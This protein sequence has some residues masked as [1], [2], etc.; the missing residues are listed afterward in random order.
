MR[1]LIVT[2]YISTPIHPAFWTKAK[3]TG[4]G[5]IIND[6]AA[7]VGKCEDVDLF[8]YVI[9]SPSISAGDFNIIGHNYL[10]L[11]RFFKF[12][13]LIMAYRFINRYPK[14]SFVEKIKIFGKSL[15]L[16]QLENIIEGYD[17]VHIHGITEA[18]SFAID[19]CKRHNVKFLVTLHG[20]ISFD[21]I[22]DA[23]IGIRCY[24]RD[25]L[26]QAVSEGITVTFVSTGIKK[27]AENYVRKVI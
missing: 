21:E 12:R 25:F 7:Y 23:P 18:T 27:I 16:G 6:I 1:I 15:V 10:S 19:I 24:E 13:N 8:A 22:A 11:I 5:Y 2:P 3:R 14:F 20:L 4:F 9:M 26:Q 17:V